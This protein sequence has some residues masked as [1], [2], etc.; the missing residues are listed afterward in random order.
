MARSCWSKGPPGSARRR[1]W[2]R[3]ARSLPP[4][5]CGSWRRAG[6]PWSATS[7][8]GSPGSSSSR[9]ARRPGPANGTRC[10]TGRPVWR[11]ACSARAEAGAVEDDIPHATTH[12]LYWLVANLAARRP[13][14]IVVDDLHWADA[15]SLRWLSHLAARIDGLPVAL[16]AAVRS[17]PD[18]PVML[19]ELRAC[20]ACTRLRLG[21]LG[22]AATTVLL[23]ERLGRAG[24]RRAVPGRATPAPA[25]IRSCS[26]RWPARCAR[27]APCG[28]N[29]SGRS[30]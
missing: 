23:R 22:L 26:S 16:L 5:A 21:P 12:G 8:T 18:E 10:W 4:L 9:F 14:M 2:A 19:D 11:P 30:P 15:P 6:W 28:W 3:L 13:L 17:G 1:C 20:P 29:T 27:T 24:R 7:P 25:G